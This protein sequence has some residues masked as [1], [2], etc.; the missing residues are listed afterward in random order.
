MMTVMSMMSM[1]AVMTMTMSSVSVVSSSFLFTLDWL[2][3]LLILW[4][5]LGI[6]SLLALK[7]IKEMLESGFLFL[8]RWDVAALENGWWEFGSHGWVSAGGLNGSR[9]APRALVGVALI[10]SGEAL[11]GAILELEEVEVIALENSG[12]EFLG[13]FLVLACWWNSS[14]FAPR[15]RAISMAG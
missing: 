3:F 6:F 11:A 10:L 4:C 8:F 7:E 14:R 1:M 12:W 2:F 15:A 5:N 13:I 9:L